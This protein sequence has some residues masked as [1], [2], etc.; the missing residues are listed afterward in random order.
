MCF[1]LLWIPFAILMYKGPVSIALYGQGA[2][3]EDAFFSSVGIWI[4]ITA[5]FGAAAVVLM[6]ASMLLGGMANIGLMARGKDAQ[7]RVLSLQDSGTRVNENPV[8]DF[9]LE[10]MPTDLPRFQAKARKLVSVVDLASMQPG[11]ELHV[12]YVPGKEY[13]AII[14][15]NDREMLRK[16]GLIT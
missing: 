5:A 9:V 6:L 8:V 15:A 16:K 3:P 11:S 10:V 1:L 7:A 2:V 12:R 13:V 14:D 4:V